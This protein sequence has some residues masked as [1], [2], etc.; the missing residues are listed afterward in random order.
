MVDFIDYDNPL[1]T[2][3]LKNMLLKGKIDCHGDMEVL[4]TLY[5]D[6][7][8]ER[9]VRISGY[10]EGNVHA[11]E[12]L[13]KKEGEVIGNMQSDYDSVII[14]KLKGDLKGENIAVSGE[15]EGN[16]TAYGFVRMTEG[17]LVK[18][19]I[20]CAHLIKD[21]NSRIDGSVQLHYSYLQR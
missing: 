3:I 7:S 14:G 12:V 10:V 13:L 19:D 11:R 21:E 17:A 5:G 9:Y 1:T 6:I 15:V 20:C 8:C 2:V 16:I 18:G 4:G